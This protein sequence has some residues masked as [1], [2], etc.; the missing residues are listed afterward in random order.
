M[1]NLRKLKERAIEEGL[2]ELKTTMIDIKSCHVEEGIMEYR[3][4]YFIEKRRK[5]FAGYI[6]YIDPIMKSLP[7]SAVR[8]GIVHEGVHIIKDVGFTRKDALEEVRHY[9]NSRVYRMKD[10]ICTDLEV[11]NRGFG[12]GLLALGKFREKHFR[13]NGFGIPSKHIEEILSRLID[14]PVPYTYK[15]YRAFFSQK[16]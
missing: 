7:E 15:E 10:E 8:S 13:H 3:N 6:I 9:K 14:L 4:I 16:N 2:S 12:Y 1:H 5:R 11:I